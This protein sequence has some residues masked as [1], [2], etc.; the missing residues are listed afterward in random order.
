VLLFSSA[1]GILSFLPTTN[2][3]NGFSVT[4]KLEIVAGSVIFNFKPKFENISFPTSL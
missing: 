1:S 3:T 4:V 2:E